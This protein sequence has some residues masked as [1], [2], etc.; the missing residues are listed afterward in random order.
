MVQGRTESHIVGTA[1]HETKFS[2][3]SGLFF[4]LFVCFYSQKLFSGTGPISESLFSYLEMLIHNNII[5]V[6]TF[7]L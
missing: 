6:N 2:K 1:G 4:C 7:A 3:V 5:F